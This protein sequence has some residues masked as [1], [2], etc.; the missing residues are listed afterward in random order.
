MKTFSDI[1]ISMPLPFMKKIFLFSALSLTYALTTAQNALP[2]SW[3]AYLIRQDSIPVIFTLQSGKENG[4]S[5]L[6]VPNTSEKITIKQVRVTKDSVNFSMPVF[7]SAFL[8]KKNTDGSLEGTWTKGTGAGFQVWPFYAYPEKASLLK[9]GQAK[10]NLSGKWDVTITRQ[11]GTLRKAVAVFNQQQNQLS[12]TFL[13]PSGDYRYLEGNQ[14]ADS[15]RL[16]AFDGSH[17]FLFTAKVDDANTLSGGLF[18]SGNNGKEKWV[19]IRNESVPLPA[20]DQPTQLR[21]GESRLAFRFNDL[22]GKQVSILDERFRNKVV[23]VQIMGSWCPNCMDETK[24][25]SEYYH[26]NKS[27]GVEVVALAY[28]NSTDIERSKKSL[29]KFQQL[30]NVQYPMLITGATASDDNKTEKTLPQLTP[31]RSFPTTIFIDRKGNVRNIKGV[32]YGPGSGIY[33]EDFKKEFYE[34]MDA[35][36]LEK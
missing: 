28:E 14:T 7:E 2:A 33:F 30:F 20:Q 1:A 17:A 19:A 24:F 32:F 16:Y 15:L 36:L 9:T 26:Q 25:L 27:R 31:I 21:E 34:Q 29:R 23:I 10:A 12:G 18:Y 3:K 4:H 13:T 35:L 22:N 5:V 11:N 8:S 6:Y